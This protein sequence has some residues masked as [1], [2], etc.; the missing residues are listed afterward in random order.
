MGT[1]LRGVFSAGAED[2][3]GSRPVPTMAITRGVGALAALGCAAASCVAA[4]GA[5]ASCLTGSCAAR[6]AFDPAAAFC[7][8]LPCSETMAG[9]LFWP[10]IGATS[11][12]FAGAEPRRT[13]SGV[14]LACDRAAGIG[15]SVEERVAVAT[16]FWMAAGRTA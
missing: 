15:V 14:A 11:W 9:W 1:P 7:W 10:A 4:A 16:M 13:G 2:T 8:P 5:A 6:G 12:L 3:A